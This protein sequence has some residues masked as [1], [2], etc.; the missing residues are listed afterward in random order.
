MHDDQHGT[1]IISAAALINALE[2]AG[3]KNRRSKNGGERCKEQQLLLV[4]NYMS[5]LVLTKKCTDV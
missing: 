5:S 4:P 2:L 1:A 3:K